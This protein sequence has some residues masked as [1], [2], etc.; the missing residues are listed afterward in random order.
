MRLSL[1]KLL[2][3][4]IEK[5]SD[6]R[7]AKMLLKKTSY[8]LIAKMFMKRKGVRCCV[9]G[10]ELGAQDSGGVATKTLCL[11]PTAYNPLPDSR[12]GMVRDGLPVIFST[13]SEARFS[14]FEPTYES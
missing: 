7:L 4:N 2:K 13:S 9:P 1:A 10:A 5:M 11:L 6:F 8:S 3:T 14:G 12:R